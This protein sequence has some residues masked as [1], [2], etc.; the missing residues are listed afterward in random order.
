MAIKGDRPQVRFGQGF[1][2]SPNRK[3]SRNQLVLA[4]AIG[5]LCWVFLDC[6]P[7]SAHSE[8]ERT[9]ESARVSI[10]ETLTRDGRSCSGLA[11]QRMVK[12]CL[13]RI[14][15]ERKSP[16]IIYMHGCAG[17]PPEHAILQG[18]QRYGLP[19]FAPDSYARPGRVNYCPPR[20]L[21]PRSNGHHR[22][23]EVTFALDQV[24][25]F[26]W[27][28]RE[29]ILIVGF[30]EGGVTTALFADPRPVGRIILGWTC[31]NSN[32]LWWQGVRGPESMPILAVL[33]GGDEIF[34]MRR[35]WRGNCG[36]FLRN[37]PKSESVVIPDAPHGIF[38]YPETDAAIRR[39]LAAVL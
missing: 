16:V 21:A 39:F 38:Y 9:W 36:A 34:K 28:D 37:R 11:S 1:E 24:S 25:K 35:E 8:V 3:W 26:P 20:R 22:S 15:S 27:V 5:V 30:S 2:A 12:D 4:A 29:R 14:V 32:D 13:T 18:L 33:G 19:I 6:L 31:H 10:P 23:E 17:L 7:A